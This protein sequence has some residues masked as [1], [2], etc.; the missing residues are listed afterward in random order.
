MNDIVVTGA[1]SLSAPIYRPNEPWAIRAEK[2]TY[3]STEG[4][5]RRV[6]NVDDVIVNLRGGGTS[7]VVSVDPVSLFYEKEPFD[8]GYASQDPSI[9]PANFLKDPHR[10]YIDYSKSPHVM[11]VDSENL[12]VGSHFQYAKI[13]KGTEIYREGQCIS[14][15]YDD[16]GV[17]INNRVGLELVAMD[18]H[19]NHHIY[20]IK[21]CNIHGDVQDGEL[22]TIALYTEDGVVGRKTSAIAEITSMVGDVSGDSNF[23]TGIRVISPYISKTEPLTLIVPIGTPVDSLAI[24]LEISYKSGRKDIISNDSV[25]FEILGLG[26]YDSMSRPREI[27]MVARYRVG[28][29]ESAIDVVCDQYITSAFNVRMFS[30]SD[31]P[32]LEIFPMMSW[33]PNEKY[34]LKWQA[35]SS[36]RSVNMDVTDLVAVYDEP[37]FIG[38][39]YNVWQSIKVRI[40]TID[41]PDVEYI[42]VHTL[43]FYIRI[44]KSD[45]GEASE[46]SDWV[47]SNLRNDLATHEEY[48]GVWFER[49]D[50][51]VFMK[52]AEDYVEAMEKTHYRLPLLSVYG[53]DITTEPTHVEALTRLGSSEIVPIE[54]ILCTLDFETTPSPTESIRLT[55]LYYEEGAKVALSTMMVLVK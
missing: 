40:N 53:E 2:D 3:T 37:G 1:D 46:N 19:E 7:I 14:V 34:I 36:D 52:G 30:L 25:R 49:M 54:E 28:R 48:T 45:N 15:N 32:G 12:V 55:F 27:D 31:T 22:L 8:M 4:S 42:M 17:V 47:I 24:H 44:N 43:E 51:C 26:L 35:I 16:E 38:D 9:A 5:G 20:G 23:I 11:V 50:S 33:G 18:S 13:F 6:P 21:R 41:I 39:M 10:I 29:E